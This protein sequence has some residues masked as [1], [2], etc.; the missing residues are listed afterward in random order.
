M[1]PKS[2]RASQAREQRNSPASLARRQNGRAALEDDWA[3]LKTQV[4]PDTLAML[5]CSYPWDLSIGVHIIRVPDS[6]ARKQQSCPVTSERL[7]K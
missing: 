4:F 5:L 2:P 7:N 6:Q 3:D 1:L